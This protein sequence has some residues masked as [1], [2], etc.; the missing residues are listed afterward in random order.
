L[1]VDRE[2]EARAILHQA[3]DDQFARIPLDW[4]WM[5]T[6]VGFAVL[7]VELEDATSAAE[8]YPVLEP[9]AGEV[10]FSGATSQGPISAYLGKL[11]S[12]LGHHDD[13]DA[14]LR[15]AL[16]V[17]LAFGWRY[18]QATTLVALSRSQQRRTGTLGEDA[19]QWLDDAE[20]I[21]AECGLSGVLAQIAEVRS[22]PS[23][24]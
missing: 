11:A 13:A 18:H 4:A 3:A 19:T 20:A 22:Q 8:L 9:Y 1:S 16:D 6:V 15:R 10:A 24:R 2:D 7:A 17:A 21:A 5:T 14:H 12:I 23:R